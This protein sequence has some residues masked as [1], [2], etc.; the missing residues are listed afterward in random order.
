MKYQYGFTF[1][2]ALTALAIISITLVI[3]LSVL[4]QF[5]ARAD[6][7]ISKQSLLQ[8]ILAAREEA[9][10]R[11]VSTG[12][13]KSDDQKHCSGKWSSGQLLFIDANGDGVIHDPAQIILVTQGKARHGNIFL[14]SFPVWRDYLIFP[15]YGL[16]P[17]DNATFWYCR[18]HDISPRWA[19]VLSKTG[20][21]RV[22]SPGADGHI[23][24]SN[25]K[26][27]AC[28]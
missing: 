28:Q 20:K 6:D 8:V 5:A 25:G 23:K 17:Y 7:E 10:M 26:L 22:I 12:L 1:I 27:L 21:T 11:H 16:M 15:P 24:D 18:I 3:T 13:C 2:E 14:R 4:S 19:I 9:H